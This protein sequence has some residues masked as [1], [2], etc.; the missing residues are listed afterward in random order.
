[1]DGAYAL[2]H[3]EGVTQD[4]SRMNKVDGI[5]AL[6]ELG[7]ADL[8]I[9][10]VL[11]SVRQYPGPA[12]YELRLR[13]R[14]GGK[15]ITLSLTSDPYSGT[16]MTFHIPR[17][18]DVVTRA[19]A[20]LPA[21]LDLTTWPTRTRTGKFEHLEW[22]DKSRSWRY[23]LETPRGIGA[24]P[25]EFVGQIWV[26]MAALWFLG[27]LA[28]AYVTRLADWMAETTVAAIRRVRSTRSGKHQLVVIKVAEGVTMMI[29][30]QAGLTDEAGEAFIDLD[31]NADGIR[32]KLLKWT[33]EAGAWLPQSDAEPYLPPDG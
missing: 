6:R 18:P 3:D 1:V 24:G 9:N 28:D 15:E 19:V 17:S 33:P 25:I 7:M 21:V 20:S 30:P 11:T 32:G 8:A 27:K 4:H 12:D 23:S 14:S 2:E 13:H 16:E 10:D 26:G 31:P 22:E 29:L 5:A